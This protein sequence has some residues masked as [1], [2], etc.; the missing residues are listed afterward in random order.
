MVNAEGFMSSHEETNKTERQMDGASYPESRC[1]SHGGG[2]R[3]VLV[4]P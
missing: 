1:T 4:R 2:R 3:G